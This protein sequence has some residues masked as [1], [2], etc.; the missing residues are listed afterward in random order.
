MQAPVDRL[1]GGDGLRFAEPAQHGRGQL[2]GRAVVLH[3]FGRDV[4]AGQHVGQCIAFHLQQAQPLHDAVGQ[5]RDAIADDHRPLAQHRFQ[6]GGAR[7][8]QDHIAGDHRFAR[9][10][11]EQVPGGIDPLQGDLRLQRLAAGSIRCRDNDLQPG[12]LRGHPAC[13]F[14]ENR[15][16]PA[17]FAEAAAGQYGQGGRVG[18]QAERGA[19][20]RAI[21]LHRNLVR[22]RMADEACI[23]RMPCVDRR[24]HREQAQHAVGAV[25]DLLGTLL[26]PGPDRRTD[27]VHR[28]HA[29]FLQ[30]AL[31]AEV[32]VGCVDADIDVRLPVQHALAEGLAQAQQARQVA[33]HLGQAH[34]GQFVRVEP[35]VAAGRTH[36]IAPDAGEFGVRE[37]RLQC[38]DQAGAESVARRFAGAKDEAGSRA[39][40]G[41]W[42]VG[43]EGFMRRNHVLHTR[44]PLSLFPVPAVVHRCNGRSPLSMNCSS[45]LT[46]ALASACSASCCLASASGSPATYS[47]R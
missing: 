27:V 12:D 43:T 17:D 3:Q 26:A 10:A 30:P 45:A 7:R 19:C 8:E 39:G 32:E 25:A 44:I 15:C 38:G 20:G 16:Q 29:A 34:H 18:R 46:S 6:S 40:N 24:F 2:F 14:E 37:A 31:D 28:A 33:Q 13:R 23:D 22:H 11:V 9:P 21:G 5:R 36:R 4:L 1:Q 35:G 47:V 41:E 42:T